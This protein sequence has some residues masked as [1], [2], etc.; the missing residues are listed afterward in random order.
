MLSDKTIFVLDTNLSMRHDKTDKWVLLVICG[1]RHPDKKI[2]PKI[3][4]VFD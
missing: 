2:T 1:A 3:Y 4:E